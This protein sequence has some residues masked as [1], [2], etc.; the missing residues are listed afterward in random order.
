MSAA[1]DDRF[2]WSKG[3]L[4]EGLACYQAKQFFEAH[5]HWEVVWLLSAEPEKTLL[6]AIIQVAASFHHLQ[7]GNEK[8]ARS[9]LRRGPAEAGALSAGACR[10]SG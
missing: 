6:Q 5:E 1:L 10:R 4:H 3:E 2:D 7:R 8:G 9:L